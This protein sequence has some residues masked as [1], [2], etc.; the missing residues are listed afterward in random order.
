MSFYIL[1]EDV[2]V[3]HIMPFTYRPQPKELLLDIRSYYSDFYFILNNYTFEMNC[4]ILL[5]DLIEF[6]IK[7]I[8][9][10]DA[11]DKV[12]TFL[13]RSITGKSK[14]LSTINCYIN[15]NFKTTLFQQLYR[16]IRTFIG[17]FTPVERTRFINDYILVYYDDLG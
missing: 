16:K 17:L 14:G 11:I 8:D 4:R 5:R 3:N 2:I 1:P 15:R 7:T 6:T 10:T 12:A 13:S 9:G